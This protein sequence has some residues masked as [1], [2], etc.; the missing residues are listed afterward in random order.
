VS[1]KKNQTPEEDNYGLPSNFVPIDAPPIN[2]NQPVGAPPPP[3]GVNPYGSGSLPSNL[4][5]QPALVKTGFPGSS[6]GPIDLFPIQSLAAANAKSQGVAAT[7][8]APAITNAAAANT[9]AKAANVTANTA[10]T[11]ANTANTN[12]TTAVTGVSTINSQTAVAIVSGV[13]QQIP[14]ST[15]G[16]TTTTPNLDNLNDG[17]TYKRVSATAL[18]NHLVDS[19]QAGFKCQAGSVVPQIVGGSASFFTYTST[20]SSIDISWSNEPVLYGDTTSSTIVGS[21]QNVTGLSASTTY[22]FYAYS[23]GSSVTFVQVSGGTGTPAMLYTPQS[24][25]A[26]QALNNQAVIA[27]SN[28]GVASTTPSSGSGGGSG[29]GSGLCVRDNT[30]VLHREKGEIPLLDCQIGDFIMGRTAWTE[31]VAMQVLPM[32]EFVRITV[33]GE[34]VSITPTHHTTTADE[35]SV[36]GKD[37]TLKDYLIRRKGYSKIKTL[38]LVEEEGRKITVTC[39]PEHEYFAGEVHPTI[40]V[41]NSVPLS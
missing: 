32:D 30:I 41:H 10:N 25:T 9:T 18:T 17:S 5:Y 23:F 29:G 1:E 19:T 22:Y 20:T 26:A 34:S 38:E 28:G 6:T 21:S 37:L 40:L 11:T 24:P 7:V 36:A 14:I 8:A 12:A 27:L 15:L 16:S 31:I 2:P 13:L 35:R 39:L 33:E 3:S 4:G